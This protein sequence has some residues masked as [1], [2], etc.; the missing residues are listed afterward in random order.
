M[1]HYCEGLSLFELTAYGK[2]F[3]GLN[4]DKKQETMWQILNLMAIITYNARL[5]QIWPNPV[6]Y[7]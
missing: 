7:L 4:D 5:A 6:I 3:W 2:K 1:Q